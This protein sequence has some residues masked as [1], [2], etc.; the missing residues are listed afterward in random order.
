MYLQ[1]YK[2]YFGFYSDIILSYQTWIG[3]TTEDRFELKEEFIARSLYGVDIDPSGIELCKFR[4]WLHLMQDL[5]VGLDEFL[6][7]NE[8]YALPNLGFKFF[9]GNSLAGDFK[10]TEIRSVLDNIGS[11]SGGGGGEGMQTKLGGRDLNEIV[12][13][14][15]EKREEYLDAHGNEKDKV[16]DELGE[17]IDEIDGLIDWESSDFWM[18]EVV[19]EAGSSFKWSVNIPEVILEGGFDIV[20]GNPPYL[21]D[22]T[23]HESSKYLGELASLLEENYEFYETIPRMNYDLYQKFIMVLF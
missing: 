1:K 10:P 13:D 2:G 7:N 6:E 4:T 5:D 22:A 21:G 15:E 11:G 19:E 8:K 9:V 20:I 23:K 17:L 14:I 16:E 12:D 3:D 18:D